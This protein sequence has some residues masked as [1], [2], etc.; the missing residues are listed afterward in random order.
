MVLGNHLLFDYEE[1]GKRY[2]AEMGL[3]LED[4]DDVLGALCAADARRR[5]EHAGLLRKSAS[6]LQRLPSQD[7]S[8]TGC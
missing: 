4:I 2:A 1:A 7:G 6:L 8:S 5:T 3:A